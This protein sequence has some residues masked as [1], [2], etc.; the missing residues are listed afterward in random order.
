MMVMTKRIKYRCCDFRVKAMGHCDPAHFSDSPWPV[1]C[2]STHRPSPAAPAASFSSQLSHNTSYLNRP[3]KLA[4]VGGS[5]ILPQPNAANFRCAAPT[6]IGGVDSTLAGC[7]LAI[8]AAD[9]R[10]ERLRIREVFWLYQS[11]KEEV[12]E[13]KLEKGSN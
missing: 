5:S 1:A 6:A 2:N 7:G 4:A 8:Y 3:S 9:L 13:R 10:A 12:S 11:S